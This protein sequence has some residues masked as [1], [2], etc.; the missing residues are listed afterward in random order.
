MLS[1]IITPLLPALPSCQHCQ[2]SAFLLIS[3]GFPVTSRWFGWF[4]LCQDRV[5]FLSLFLDPI[6]LHLLGRLLFACKLLVKERLCKQSFL[7]EQ[8][9]LFSYMV[10]TK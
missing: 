8:E 9:A 6:E 7:F 10:V 2:P 5:P 3:F 4:T 1:G